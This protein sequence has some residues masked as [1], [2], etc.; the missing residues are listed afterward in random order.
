M[1]HS[2][3]THTAFVHAALDLGG[4]EAA[5]EAIK[6]MR[7]DGFVPNLALYNKASS[8]DTPT[9]ALGNPSRD[10]LR[11][12]KALVC[13][14]SGVQTSANPSGSLAPPPPFFFPVYLYRTK[15]TL[16]HPLSVYSSQYAGG[17][18][19]MSPEKVCLVIGRDGE[20]YLAGESRHKLVFS[21][22]VCLPVL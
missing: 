13:R 4:P 7:R 9:G 11:R 5:L 12:W 3:R 8:R 15:T 18:S 17:F 20:K 10:P 2:F 21:L 19:L 1:H 22:S 16:I 6:G 14:S